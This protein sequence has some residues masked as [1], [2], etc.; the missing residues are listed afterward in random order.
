MKKYILLFL[1]LS[2]VLPYANAGWALEPIDV[3]SYYDLYAENPDW[4]E[5]SVVTSQVWKADVVTIN[6][7]TY[8]NSSLGS[9]TFDWFCA[10]DANGDCVGE[11]EGEEEEE[12]GEDDEEE[13]NNSDDCGETT[14]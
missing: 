11:D 10:E 3:P 1:F 9:A 2:F 7:N 5:A 12:E 6:S 8:A 4:V 13:Q 14:Y